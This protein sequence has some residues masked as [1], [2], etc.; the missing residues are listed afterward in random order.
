MMEGIYLLNVTIAGVKSINEPVTLEFYK[1]QV[2][3]SF[4]PD[5]YRI[6]AIY[7]ENG[8]GKTALIT[9]IDI[10]KKIIT[11]DS[12]LEQV[13]NQEFL[14][15][16]INK[17]TK[18]F[19]FSAE[20]VNKDEEIFEMYKYELKL[21]RDANGMFVIQLE[22]LQMRNA[23]TVTNPYR[24]VFE[25]VDGKISELNCLNESVTD[26]IEKRTMNLLS[27]SSFI[28]ILFHFDNSEYA[29]DM[30]FYCQVM[31]TFLLFY[32]IQIYL[33]EED[34]HETYLMNQK[35]QLTKSF[36][37]NLKKELDEVQKR[38]DSFTIEKNVTIIRKEDIKQYE[39]KIRKLEKFIKL[40]KRDLKK[41]EI[42]KKD[43]GK[44]YRCEL[45]F[46]YSGYS[47]NKEFESTGIKKLVSLFNS[48]NI[49]SKGG[50]VFID[51]MD[52]NINDIYLGKMIEYFKNYGEGQLC[53]TLHNPGPMNV[54]K[55]NKNS[56]E[57]LSNDNKL[58]TWTRRG[59]STPENCYRY[60]LIDNLPFNIEASDFIGILGD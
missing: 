24:N 54:L 18:E 31:L 30:D 9:G 51:E 7:G 8:S 20:F 45:T 55:D 36:N 39:S 14:N 35:I 4:D 40:F 37:G 13:T 43:D 44:F 22:R 60:G 25:V 49:A 5:K 27:K 50:I 28:R 6:K 46:N 52:S 57:F 1:K 59:N 41:I 3:K 38:L 34:Q 47:V 17:K 21:T 53:F 56:I 48:L 33:D 10:A 15:E 58:T 42:D 19:Y 26:K 12:Y 16:I 11:S 23:R 2:S 32:S 29:E